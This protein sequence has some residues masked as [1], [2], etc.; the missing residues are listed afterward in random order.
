MED[1][2]LLQEGQAELPGDGTVAA[3]GDE[4]TRFNVWDA[5]VRLSWPRPLIRDLADGGGWG[6]YTP[7]VLWGGDC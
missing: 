7:E 4:G 3:Q 6:R 1:P 5:V 2:C